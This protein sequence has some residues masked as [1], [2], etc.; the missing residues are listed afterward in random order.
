MHTSTQRRKSSPISIY[1]RS[2]SS[3]VSSLLPL[4][5]EP[6]VAGVGGSS[7]KVKRVSGVRTVV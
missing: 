6:I 3:A 5:E 1:T 2:I 7:S 4:Q